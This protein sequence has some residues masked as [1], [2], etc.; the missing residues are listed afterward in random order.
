MGG[1]GSIM[2]RKMKRNKMKYSVELSLSLLSS[3]V[4]MFYTRIFHVICD[5][6]FFGRF[7]DTL[8]FDLLCRMRRHVGF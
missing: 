2:K 4:L 6:V 5:C 1:G 7:D 8:L 3:S